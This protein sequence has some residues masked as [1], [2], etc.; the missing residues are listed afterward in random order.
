MSKANIVLFRVNIRGCAGI[1]GNKRHEVAKQLEIRKAFKMNATWTTRLSDDAALLNQETTATAQEKPTEAKPAD[2]HG[3]KGKPQEKEA[4]S[5][6]TETLQKARQNPGANLI[7]IFRAG[8]RRI[9]LFPE[10]N[11]A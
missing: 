11:K 6:G 4:A 2:K 10:V 9:V 3:G 5:A 8:F 1:D 7:S